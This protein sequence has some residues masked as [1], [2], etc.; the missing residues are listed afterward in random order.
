M[1]NTRNGSD[2]YHLGTVKG[3]L[4]VVDRGRVCIDAFCKGNETIYYNWYRFN[5]TRDDYD[6]IQ[7]YKDKECYF[8]GNLSRPVSD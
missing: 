2:T 7:D 6:P 5:S 3:S 4:T 1:T 8:D